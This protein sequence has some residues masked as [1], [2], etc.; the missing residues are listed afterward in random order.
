MTKGL[1]AHYG[2]R[3]DS[4]KGFVQSD[5]SGC[6]ST[7]DDAVDYRSRAPCPALTELIMQGLLYNGAEVPK[8]F[9]P[10]VPEETA[11]TMPKP[12]NIRIPRR[13]E[14]EKTQ[15]YHS[16][17]SDNTSASQSSESGVKPRRR[18]KPQP[19]PQLRT[20]PSL[21]PI[22]DMNLNSGDERSVSIDINGSDSDS[23][24]SSGVYLSQTES[25]SVT[26]SGSTSTSVSEAQNSARMPHYN[27]ANPYN[28][29]PY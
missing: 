1:K 6:T 18:M 16:S 3:G 8:S 9:D 29:K 15:R 20:S 22:V 23:N 2:A 12:A 19:K 4:T 13:A 21:L 26:Q 10:F 27:P 7:D 5:G 25:G 28:Y 11:A 14:T 24:A 17:D